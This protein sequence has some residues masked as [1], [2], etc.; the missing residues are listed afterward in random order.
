MGFGFSIGDVEAWLLLA[1][2]ICTD[3]FLNL[4]VKMHKLVSIIVR[5][6]L[7]ALG[8]MRV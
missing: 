7:T 4:E 3:L 2:W 5:T 1:A 8:A 6:G